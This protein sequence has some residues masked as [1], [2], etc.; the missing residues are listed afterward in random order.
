M[1]TL[2]S[3]IIHP[4]ILR[5]RDFAT[6]ISRVANAAT[7]GNNRAMTCLDTA[8]LSRKLMRY[9]LAFPFH[10]NP[11]PSPQTTYLN[12][13]CLMTAHTIRA[14]ISTSTPVTKDSSTNKLDHNK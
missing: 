4:A 9:V 2:P 7:T 6:T 10:Y 14:H 5:T 11:S 12:V 1:H 8:R 3:Q 13:P